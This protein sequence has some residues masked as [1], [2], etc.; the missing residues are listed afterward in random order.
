MKSRCIGKFPF[1]ATKCPDSLTGQD[2]RVLPQAREK[3]AELKVTLL[4]REGL[5]AISAWS[6][7]DAAA[8]DRILT[9]LHRLALFIR[10]DPRR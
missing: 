8:H 4:R 3:V 1:V 5:A 9:A 7:L 10:Y 6:F 2:H